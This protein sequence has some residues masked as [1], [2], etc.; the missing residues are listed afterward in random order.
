LTDEHANQACGKA[1]SDADEDG[2]ENMESSSLQGMKE[3]RQAMVSVVTV[4][5]VLG[6]MTIV[7]VKS[8]RRRVFGPA[9]LF[10]ASGVIDC[11]S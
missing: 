10:L 5:S 9:T 4:R 2:N 3:S 6:I 11:R 7:A 1:G 8:L